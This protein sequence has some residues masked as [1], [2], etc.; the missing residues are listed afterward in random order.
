MP[1]QDFLID[2]DDPF[3]LLEGGGESFVTYAGSQDLEATISQHPEIFQS[4][5]GCEL[6]ELAN[7]SFDEEDFSH[8][9]ELFGRTDIC[10]INFSDKC[11]TNPQPSSFYNFLEKLQNGRKPELCISFTETGLDIEPGEEVP[12]PQSFLL[13][14]DLFD[15]AFDHK[16]TGVNA[17]NANIEFHDLRRNVDIF[18]IA[19]FIEE[20]CKQLST[21]YH[22]VVDQRNFLGNGNLFSDELLRN[23]SCEDE[24]TTEIEAAKYVDRILNRNQVPCHSMAAREDDSNPPVK[25]LKLDHLTSSIESY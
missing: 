10:D 9:G 13:I 19:F 7:L 5:E 3:I 15:F 24:E 4:E 21:A 25:K 23:L 16:P 18:N 8:L 11:K 6:V 20:V 14:K 2:E 1:I 22:G 12:T 17:R